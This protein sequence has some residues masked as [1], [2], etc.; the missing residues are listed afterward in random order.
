MDDG[1]R[2]GLGE[3]GARAGAAAIAGALSVLLALVGPVGALARTPLNSTHLGFA[4]A[5]FLVTLISVSIAAY[6][7]ATLFTPMPLLARYLNLE[8]KERATLE[9]DLIEAKL[10]NSSNSSTEK[11]LQ[12]FGRRVD[13]AHEVIAGGEADAKAFSAAQNILTSSIEVLNF[14]SRWERETA[15][16]KK[17][18][19]IFIPIGF[20]VLGGL[21]FTYAANPTPHTLVS[22][23]VPVTVMLNANGW[24]RLLCRPQ[25]QPI[26]LAGVAVDGELRE[27]AVIL[28]PIDKCKEAQA[29]EVS[30]DLGHAIPRVV[31]SIPAPAPLPAG[32]TK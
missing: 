17:K 21:L 10:L 29:L 15:W 7:I 30:S 12:E 5:G 14:A 11:T 9:R 25:D 27:P 13:Y 2:V 1:G 20:A 28:D 24:H 31:I 3:A 22:A 23:P 6:Q 32:T 4:V 16:E 18:R 19:W 26:P 8:S